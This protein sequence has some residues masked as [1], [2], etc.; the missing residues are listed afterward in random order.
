M[1]KYFQCLLVLYGIRDRWLPWT[2]RLL[3]LLG[4]LDDLSFVFVVSESWHDPN[5]SEHSIWTDLD[6]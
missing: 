4:T 1:V 5:Q 6:Q 3:L 2:E